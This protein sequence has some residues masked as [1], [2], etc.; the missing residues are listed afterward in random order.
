MRLNATEL[1]DAHAVVS[2]LGELVERR[3]ATYE[4]AVELATA[5]DPTPDL[6]PT[7]IDNPMLRGHLAEVLGGKRDLDIAQLTSLEMAVGESGRWEVAQ[8]P[9]RIASAPSAGIRLAAAL[10]RV[11]AELG[12]H[13]EG[14]IDEHLVDE[15]S[16]IYQPASH[17]LRGGVELAFSVSPDLMA[18]L[19]PHVTLIAMV[20]RDR[21][22][23][24]GSASARE[25]PGL[26]VLPTPVTALEA[27]EA[28]VHESAHQ[29]FFDLA[30]VGSIFSG[31]YARSP[32]FR[33]PWAPSASHPW[34]FE[35]TIAA[36][37]AYS[38][39][40]TFWAKCEE[41]DLG[42]LHSKSLLPRAADRA[43]ILG[44]WIV[45]RSEFLGHDG[46]ELIRG[47]LGKPIRGG[48][49][50]NLVDPH[51]L[52]ARA[53]TAGEPFAVRRCGRWRLVVRWTRPPEIT[54]LRS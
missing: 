2:P 18:D 43:S 22:R 21:A 6:D 23:Q 53:V 25:Y 47:L 15:R 44:S 40:A 28:L 26:V 33:P 54:W 11:G 27:A 50:N 17:I 1:V 45:D 35:Q 14:D 49:P 9:V 34:P 38:C 42:P 20:H 31:N 7:M 4:I 52:L 39:L 12:R 36:F 37:H 46:H 13:G 19:M 3:R 29:K 10:R 24:L 8:I 5:S 32:L 16:P 41:H 51:E 30:I 48:R